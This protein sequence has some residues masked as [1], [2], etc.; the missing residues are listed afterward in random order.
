VTSFSAFVEV[1]TA[2]VYTAGTSS[3]T[4]AVG[5]SLPICFGCSQW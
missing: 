2:L 4:V 3:R 1:T 5:G